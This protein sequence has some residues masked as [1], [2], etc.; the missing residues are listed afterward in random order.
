MDRKLT[1]PAN[2]ADTFVVLKPDL[3][4]DSED[5]TDTFFGE[6]NARYNGF[7]Q[8]ML[9][10][11]FSFNEDWSTWEMHPNGDEFVC[12]LSGDVEFLL[13]DAEGE[14]S[15]RLNSP[16]SF[17]VVPQNTWH[18]A[19]VAQPAKM[20]FVTPGEGTKNQEVPPV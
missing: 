18:K 4:A 16:G 9:I 11:S 5:V 8:H 3:T 20:I 1:K 6:L 2:I 19:I 15:L 17:V 13:R 12:L 7:K 14:R 10:S